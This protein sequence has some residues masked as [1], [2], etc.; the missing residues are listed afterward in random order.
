MQANVGGVRIRGVMFPASYEGDVA[1][2]KDLAAGVK[3]HAAP[4]PPQT[5]RSQRSRDVRARPHTGGTS[6]SLSGPTAKSCS[7]F[8][9]RR[10]PNMYSSTYV[11][12]TRYLP[13]SKRASRFVL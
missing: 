12:S 8:D 11:L 4:A 1:Q 13:P 6:F 10:L 7:L 9:R 2:G 5:G 3:D